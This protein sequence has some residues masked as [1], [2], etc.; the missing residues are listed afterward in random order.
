MSVKII[1]RDISN[2]VDDSNHQPTISTSASIHTEQN[3]KKGIVMV[4]SHLFLVCCSN[5]LSSG[6]ES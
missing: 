2:M 5:A 6:A 1:Y 3:E 4:S